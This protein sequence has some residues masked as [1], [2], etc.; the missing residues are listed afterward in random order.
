[1]ASFEE[2]YSLIC[3][4]NGGARDSITPILVPIGDRECSILP[5]EVHS[6]LATHALTLIGFLSESTQ[7]DAL[8][9]AVFDMSAANP[10]KILKAQIALAFIDLQLELPSMEIKLLHR[11]AFVKELQILGIGVLGSGSGETPANSSPTSN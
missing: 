6:H 5:V 11:E 3:I 7:F 10:D 4:P 1:M 9:K 8:K 2:R